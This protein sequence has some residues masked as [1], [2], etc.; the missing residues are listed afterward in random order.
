MLEQA[1]LMGLCTLAALVFAG[2]AA[3]DETTKGKIKVAV[4]ADSLATNSDVPWPAVLAKHLGDGYEVNVFAAN[5][6]T[7]LS[8]TYR[9]IWTRYEHVKAADYRGDITLVCFGANG[10]KPDNWR[11]KDEWAALYKRL[12]GMYTGANRKVY[13]VLPPPATTDSPYGIS[14][15]ILHNQTIPS[16]KQIAKDTGCE[17]IDTFTPLVGRS[18]VTGQDGLYPTPVGH[19]IMGAVVLKALTGKEVA[20]PAAPKPPT[21]EEIAAK[22]AAKAV[23]AQH[24]KAMNVGDVAELT[25]EY[26]ADPK[27][28]GP[29]GKGNTEDD[30]W[31]FW[32]ELCHA[33]KSYHRLSLATKTMPED[34]R[35]N[36]IFDPK[37]KAGH[38]KK[39]TGPIA[40]MLPNPQDTE[41]WIFS[42]DWDGRYEGFWGD[43]KVKQVLAHPFV[44]KN[45]HCCVAVSFRVPADGAYDVSG[46]LT[47]LT[48]VN[49]PQMTG[50]LWQIELSKEWTG[51]D[52]PEAY[53]IAA[54]GGPIG[55]G[56]GP[57]SAEIEARGVECKMGNTIRLVIDPNNQWGSDLTR[58]E[59]FRIKRVK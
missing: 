42:S 45:S 23:K 54:K 34:Q 18:D 1:K 38:Q 33:R 15:D 55:D 29:D 12:I 8:N 21:Q 10:A 59:N 31:Q 35:K 57:D 26:V 27:G 58:I 36:G 56:K 41:G 46:K 11:R 5:G 30:T 37:S 3:A 6:L 39:V 22:D 16:L 4:V 14:R 32:F 50:I 2:A 51:S 43:L 28:D 24:V 9:S 7:V 47:D 48:V 52:S 49:M 13:I 40:G 19:E 17:V 20:I 44:E 25:P 53:K